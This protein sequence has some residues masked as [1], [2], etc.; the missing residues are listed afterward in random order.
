[1]HVLFVGGLLG[2]PTESL[3]NGKT[4]LLSVCVCVCTSASASVWHMTC[5]VFRVGCVCRV[6]AYCFF[7]RVYAS[8]SPVL[9]RGMRVHDLKKFTPLAVVVNS[10][11]MH[12]IV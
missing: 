3:D 1:M 4:A 9:G 10:P 5:F 2:A 12:L 7:C 8:H 11:C 6:R